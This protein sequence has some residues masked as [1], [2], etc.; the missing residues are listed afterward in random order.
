MEA[1]EVNIDH[2]AA[3]ITFSQP[4]TQPVV[5]ANMITRNGTDPCVIR[6]SNV[7]T[8][9]FTARLQEYEYLDGNHVPE[10]ISYLVMEKGN[11]TLNDGTMI[12]AGTFETDA[13]TATA[14]QSLR[15]TMN[16]QPVILSSIVTTNEAE[17]VTGRIRNI[18]T[19]GFEY[20]LQEQEKNS[21]DHGSETVAYIAWEP[22]YGLQKGMRYAAD[23]T[24]N[25]ITHKSKAIGYNQTFAAKP[26][27]LAGMQT[28]NGKDTSLLRVTKTTTAAMTVFVEEEK[29]HNKE[30]NHTNEQAGYLVI[31]QE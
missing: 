2:N 25:T 12:E 31:T 30:V 8:T 17:A 16:R 27:V 11:Y 29:S 3:R 6:I 9:G 5:V 18:S 10:T 19:S 21:K 20:L 24:E 14:L 22:G 15:K 4:F 7:D 28:T 1:G 13:T 26:F 23:I